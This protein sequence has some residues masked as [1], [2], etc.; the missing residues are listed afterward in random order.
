MKILICIGFILGISLLIFVLIYQLKSK[1]IDKLKNEKL[2]KLDQE[3]SVLIDELKS[4][5]MNK[6]IKDEYMLKL[7]QIQEQVKILRQQ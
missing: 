3:T 6:L 5:E 2:L 4:T 1:K 7:H